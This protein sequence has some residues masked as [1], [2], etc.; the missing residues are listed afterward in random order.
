MMLEY[1]QDCMHCCRL[2]ETLSPIGVLC[3]C[4]GADVHASTRVGGATPLHRAAFM[5]HLGMTEL[6]CVLE[7]LRP[8][9]TTH[10]ALLISQLPDRL[11]R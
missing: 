11:M 10:I 9:L 8:C 3:L 2:L 7:R 4:P 5:G 6:L 1:I